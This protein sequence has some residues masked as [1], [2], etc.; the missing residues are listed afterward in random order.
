MIVRKIIK[1][2]TETVGDGPVIAA[3]ASTIVGIFY[4]LRAAGVGQH[5]ALLTSTW[6]A[7]LVSLQA[8]EM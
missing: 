1:N 4:T 3:V 2:L 7:C 8:W 5:S 6:L